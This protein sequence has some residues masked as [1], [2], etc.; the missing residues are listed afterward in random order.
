[1]IRHPY[2]FVPFAKP[3]VATRALTPSQV[4]GHERIQPQLYSGTLHCELETL[5]PLSIK[6][7]FK[8]LRKRGNRAWIP[9]SSIKGM[10]RNVAEMIGAGCTLYF[11]YTKA[12]ERTPTEPITPIHACKAGQACLVCRVFGYAPPG[13]EG[14]WQGKAQ[15]HDSDSLK[16]VQWMESPGGGSVRLQF[17]MPGTQLS[18][19]RPAP[20]PDG[21]FIRTRAM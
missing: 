18:T 19:A 3:P 21:R 9:G 2:R 11:K 17:K 8:D 10:A 6:Q 4:A 13:E 1:L 16:G 14:G 5:T 7:H 15:F 12:G 20:P